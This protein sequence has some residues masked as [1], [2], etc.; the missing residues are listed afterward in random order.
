MKINSYIAFSGNC[1][2]ALQFY[3]S[4]LGGDIVNKQ[5]YKDSS[6][7]IPENYRDKLEH[8]EL[9]GKGFHLMAYDASPDT[10]LNNGNKIHIS[11]DLRD[12]NKARELFK[13]LSD[14]GITNHP[15]SEKDW[16]A[17]YGRCTDE[18]G[19]HWMINCKK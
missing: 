4:L 1:M 6:M 16:G 19:V 9:K 18:F 5:Y 2:Q 14:K 17:L 7:D 3:Q 11:V 10:P 13:E 12:E 15:F 8:A